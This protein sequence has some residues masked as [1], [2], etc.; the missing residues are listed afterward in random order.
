MLNIEKLTVK[1]I[2]FLHDEDL[3]NPYFKVPCD[4]NHVLPGFKKY[5][6]LGGEGDYQLNNYFIGR[7]LIDV[8][9]LFDILDWQCPFFLTSM[10]VPSYIIQP[11]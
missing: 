5:I 10:T 6:F 2:L 4:H 3:S 9:T 8:L 11:Y 1:D 7:V